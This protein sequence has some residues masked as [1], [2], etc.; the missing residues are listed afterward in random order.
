MKRIRV[1]LADDHALV[2]AGVRALLERLEDIEVVAEAGD[3]KETVS[4][5]RRYRPDLV[6]LDIAMPVFSGFEVLGII[7]KEFPDVKVIVLSVHEGEEY[8][9]TALRAGANGYLPKKAASDELQKAIRAVMQGETYL[10][11]EISKHAVPNYRRARP[12]LVAAEEL[13]PRQLDVLRMIA[14]GFT[15]K[16]IARTLNIS[17]KTVETHR[18]LLMERLNIRDVAGLVRYAIRTG[19][20]TVD[21]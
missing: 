4:L 7:A 5:I 18:A 3:G 12:D 21:Q 14:G 6:I 20:V 13:T 2:R 10:S 17:V 15:T 9:L 19:L 8:A 1:L 16:E 11:P